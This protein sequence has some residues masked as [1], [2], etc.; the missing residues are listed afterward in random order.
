MNTSLELH[1][2]NEV[3]FLTYRDILICYGLDRNDLSLI[4]HFLPIRRRLGKQIVGHPNWRY[5]QTSAKGEYN[6]P[7]P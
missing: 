5:F 1:L 6:V 7:P 3:T 4:T 2:L